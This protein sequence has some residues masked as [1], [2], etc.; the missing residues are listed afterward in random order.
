MAKVVIMPVSGS[1]TTS[2]W[3]VLNP[4]VTPM[5]TTLAVAASGSVVYSCAYTLD[6]PNDTVNPSSAV[7]PLSWPIATLTT[8]T[9]SVS[10]N[11]IQPVMAVNCTITSGT[12]TV[13]FYVLQAGLKQS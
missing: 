6:D 3:V 1:G 7:P 4:Q 11:L 10:Y 2:P 8:Q 13:V 12:G 5:N 9:A